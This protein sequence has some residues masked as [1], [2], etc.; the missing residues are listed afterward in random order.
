MISDTI[1]TDFNFD[2]LKNLNRVILR[3]DCITCNAK[4]NYVIA[5]LMHPFILLFKEAVESSLN[6]TIIIVDKADA[7]V[8]N[9]NDYEDYVNNLSQIDLILDLTLRNAGIENINDN[10]E[11]TYPIMYSSLSIL[12]HP[13]GNRSPLEKMFNFY[14]IL[15]ITSTIIILITTFFVLLY[16][17]NNQKKKFI[18][19]ALFE[20]LRLLTNSSINTKI[21]TMPLRIYF[22]VIFLYFLII[23]AT[24]QG[25]LAEF[26]TKPESRCNIETIDDIQLDTQIQKIY[27]PLGPTITSAKSDDNYENLFFRLT[28]LSLDFRPDW[29]E[30]I[31]NDKSG[32]YIDDYL[33]LNY[34]AKKYQLHISKYPISTMNYY[35]FQT[36]RNLPLIERINSVIMRLIE[37]GIANVWYKRI[38]TDGI[39]KL[40]KNSAG[41]G[42]ITD[43]FRSI[44]FCDLEFAFLL[45]AVGSMIA[46]VCFIVEISIIVRKRKIDKKRQKRNQ[47]HFILQPI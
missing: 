28:S 27:F 16:F 36:R 8:N 44:I 22:S 21:N 12:S 30:N 29:I 3:A 46:I 4:N 34:F 38:Q 26:L 18:A 11:L 13:R 39:I 20:L 17:S 31:I 19:F 37:S 14:G 9:N 40:T 15:I 24:F 41:N 33:L 6:I 10:I 43:G 32:V 25:H 42:K 47:T 1:C 5:S 2:R 23:Q 7:I 45:W 35:S